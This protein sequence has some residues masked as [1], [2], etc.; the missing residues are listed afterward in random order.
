MSAMTKKP[1]MFRYEMREC[2]AEE[3]RHAAL[4]LRIIAGMLDLAASGRDT[5]FNHESIGRHVRCVLAEDDSHLAAAVGILG[6]TERAV[7]DDETGD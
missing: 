7:N 5:H 4:E 6:K 3:V 2:D 1:A